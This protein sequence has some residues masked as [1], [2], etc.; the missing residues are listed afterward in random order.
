MAK[1]ILVVNYCIDGL[2]QEQ[3]VKNFRDLRSS[4]EGSKIADEYYTFFLPV[5]TDSHIQVFYEKD[6]DDIGYD[7]LKRLIEEKI[8]NF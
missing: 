1:P 2:S 6:L 5:K 3:I 4:V 7:E 8:K